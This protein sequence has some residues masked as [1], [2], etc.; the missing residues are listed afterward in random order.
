MKFAMSTEFQKTH[1]TELSQWT[2]ICDGATQF[3]NPILDRWKSAMSYF[4][5]INPNVEIHPMVHN[6]YDLLIFYNSRINGDRW[7]NNEQ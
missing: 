5:R 6:K 4:D 1:L 2:K 3:V 7:I